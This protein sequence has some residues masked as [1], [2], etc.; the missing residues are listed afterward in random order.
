[1]AINKYSEEF[2]K[3][4]ESYFLNNKE[5]SCRELGKIFNISN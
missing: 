5:M 3:E 2:V 4:V 1:M